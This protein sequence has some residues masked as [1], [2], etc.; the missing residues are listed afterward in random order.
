MALARITQPL[1]RVK[2]LK[3]GPHREIQT[4]TITSVAQEKELLL[5]G[6]ATSRVEQTGTFKHIS[7][8]S[9]AEQ[10]ARLIE[11]RAMTAGELPPPA[12]VIEGEIVENEGR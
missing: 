6:G 2:R 12:E 1:G 5:S 4:L 11:L 9:P 10:R 3:S 7:E 8:M